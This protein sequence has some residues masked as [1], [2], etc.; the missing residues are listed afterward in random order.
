MW[1]DKKPTWR[2][3]PLNCRQK[4]LSLNFFQQV[5]SF[6]KDTPGWHIHRVH[7]QK[8]KK[9]KKNKKKNLPHMLS[10]LQN[11]YDIS[12]IYHH[13]KLNLSLFF[14]RGCHSV[15]R[16]EISLHIAH[17]KLEQSHSVLVFPLPLPLIFVHLISYL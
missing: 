17:Q 10:Y 15:V 7:F 12:Y 4:F 5:Q 6:C 8:L 13:S 3:M 2:P 16:Y 11:I 14:G 1:F 9:K